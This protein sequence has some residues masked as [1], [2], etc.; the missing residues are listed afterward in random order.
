VSQLKTDPATGRLVREG[1]A[2]VRVTGAEEV[3]Q[4]LATR[5]RLIRGEVPTDLTRGMLYFGEIPAILSKGTDTNLIEGQYI[6]VAL[7]TPGI[8]Q[9]DD[10]EGTYDAAERT[11]TI[12]IDAT[13]GLDDARRRVPL[14]DT[15]EIRFG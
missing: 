3:A 7:G 14:H 9:V 12:S 2:F 5:W 4:H 1:G 6:D 10:L 11:A 15:F 13:I 8:V